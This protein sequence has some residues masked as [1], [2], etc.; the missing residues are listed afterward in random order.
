MA[1]VLVEAMK[2]QE[3]VIDSQKGEL[4]AVKA[5]LDGLQKLV[6]KLAEEAKAGYGLTK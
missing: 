5:Q 3:K 1:P 6:E 2:E 4:S